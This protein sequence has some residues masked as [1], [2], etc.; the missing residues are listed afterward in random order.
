MNVQ[1]TVFPANP[2]HDFLGALDQSFVCLH[3]TDTVPGLTFDPLSR[4][5]SERLQAI[6]GRD[7]AKTFLGL[8]ADVY[9]AKRFWQELPAPWSRLLEDIWPAPLTVIWKANSRAP[10]VM[11]ATCARF[12]GIKLEDHLLVE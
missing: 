4:K 9:E 1:E 7:P 6:K 5:A 3:P 11:V 12:A 8:V 2:T 10:K